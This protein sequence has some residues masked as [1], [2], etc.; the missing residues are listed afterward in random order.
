MRLHDLWPGKVDVDLTQVPGN[1]SRGNGG[2]SSSWVSSRAWCSTI[3]ELIRGS[4]DALKH[5]GSSGQDSGKEAGHGS[6]LTVKS[7]R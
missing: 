7:S 4:G 3:A 2:P 5:D 1:K 6:G